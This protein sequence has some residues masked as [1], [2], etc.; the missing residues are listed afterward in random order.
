M[1]GKKERKEKAKARNLS[2]CPDE[3]V[4]L[5]SVYRSASPMHVES[6]LQSCSL[7]GAEREMMAMTSVTSACLSERPC[8]WLIITRGE[9]SSGTSQ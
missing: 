5:C 7:S 3:S 4:L 8:H 1:D 2:R 9:G 6:Y